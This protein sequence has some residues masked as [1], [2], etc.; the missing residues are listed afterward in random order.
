LGS[1]AST[2]STAALNGDD[3][4]YAQLEGALSEL[5]ADRDAVASQI[6]DVLNAATFAGH[7]LTKSEARDLIH[8]GNEIIWRAQALAASAGESS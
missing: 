5:T 1:R 6:R 3:A 2:V 8:M 4:T 7:Q